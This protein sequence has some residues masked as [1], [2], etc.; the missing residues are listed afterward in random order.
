M[1]DPHNPPGVNLGPPAG[2]GRGTGLALLS[3]EGQVGISGTYDKCRHTYLY[4]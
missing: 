1:D 3:L 4:T 2:G